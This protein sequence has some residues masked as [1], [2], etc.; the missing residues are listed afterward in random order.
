M[1]SVQLLFNQLDPRLKEATS[2]SPAPGP[3]LS[4]NLPLEVFSALACITSLLLWNLDLL[5]HRL[6]GADPGRGP[7][8]LPLGSAAASQD[9]LGFCLS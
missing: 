3:P 9:L 7:T 6:N 4:L 8:Q 1:S 5:L 2:A